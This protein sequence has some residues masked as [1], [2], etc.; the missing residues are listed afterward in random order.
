MPTNRT[1]P[2]R[3]VDRAHR[4]SFAL[5][6]RVA[7]RLASKH[8]TARDCAVYT[9]RCLMHWLGPNAF[10]D[11]LRRADKDYDRDVETYGTA[12]PVKPNEHIRPW[13]D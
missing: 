5:M 7:A 12:Q 9:L 3:F 4:F 2:N 13:Q 11:A 1:T 8:M 6:S 10:D